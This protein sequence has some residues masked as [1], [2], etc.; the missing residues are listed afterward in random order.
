MFQGE[1]L[2]V[3]K[4]SKDSTVRIQGYSYRCAVKQHSKDTR[5]FQGEIRT[6]VL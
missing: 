5:I 6:A 1:I 3:S 4:D 2:T